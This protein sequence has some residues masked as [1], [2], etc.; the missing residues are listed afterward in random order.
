[1]HYHET[2][3]KDEPLCVYFSFTTAQSKN[4]KF[5]LVPKKNPTKNYPIGI[6]VDKTWIHRIIQKAAL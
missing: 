5:G 3:A 1:M 4:L 6:A 2:W